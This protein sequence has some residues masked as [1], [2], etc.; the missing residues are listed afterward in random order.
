MDQTEN[1]P[2]VR[3]ALISHVKASRLRGVSLKDFITFKS[4]RELYETQGE[5][6]NE[7]PAANICPTSNK[8][9]IKDADLQIFFATG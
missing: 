6:K 7:E 1:K 9:S 5:E 2:T 4:L 3:Q 8:V